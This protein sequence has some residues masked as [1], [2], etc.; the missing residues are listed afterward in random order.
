M[1]VSIVMSALTKPQL[2]HNNRKPTALIL[3]SIQVQCQAHH[4]PKKVLSMRL[5]LYLDIYTAQHAEINQNRLVQSPLYRA[6][7]TVTYNY[8]QNRL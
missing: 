7:Y 5:L 3:L 8:N 1:I 4:K 2:A 6:I